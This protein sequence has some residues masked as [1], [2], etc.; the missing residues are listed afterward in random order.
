[1]TPTCRR[2]RR[3]S[4]FVLFA[5]ALAACGG[6]APASGAT[7]KIGA[8]VPTTGRYAAGG[9]LV[10]NGYELAIEDINKAGGVDVNGTKMQLEL[11]V[12]DRKSTRLNSS[13]VRISYAVF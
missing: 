4:L 7:I 8:V 13:H 12:L 3:L 2:F 9:E 11:T 5:L 10:K 6:A 1:M